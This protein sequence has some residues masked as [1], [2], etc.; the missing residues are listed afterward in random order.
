MSQ[1]GPSWLVLLGVALLVM[2]VVRGLF[3]QSFYV[4][5]GSMEP[6]IEPGD[7]ILVNKMAGAGDL[8]RGDVVVFDGST[9]FVT[10][11][12]TPAWS[13]GVIGRALSGAASLFG[14]DLGEQDF[15]KRIVGLPG[16]RVV[17]CDGEGG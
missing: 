7:R 11:D 16:D 17:C 10:D 3:V 13:E 5:S 8:R 14:V 6:A 9:S 15:V 1:R 4:P 2:L 12:R